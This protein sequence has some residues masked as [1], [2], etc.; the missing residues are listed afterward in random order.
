LSNEYETPSKNNAN[1]DENAN[2][3][4]NGYTHTIY[5]QKQLKIAAMPKEAKQK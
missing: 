2:N 1:N 5:Q 3:G 4:R